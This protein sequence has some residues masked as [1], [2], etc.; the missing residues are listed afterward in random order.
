VATTRQIRAGLATNL[1]TIPNVQ[2]SAYMIANPTPPTVWVRPDK[3]SYHEAMQNGLACKYFTVTAFVGV[4]ADQGSQML[5]DKM[6]DETGATSVKA[7]IESD[8]TLGGLV[9]DLIVTDHNG[10]QVFADPQVGR[11]MG[12]GQLLA[13]DWTVEVYV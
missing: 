1:A 13:A 4:I 7:A 10:Y 6:L 2:A 5:L 3:T 11:S 8:K 9:Q 12:Q